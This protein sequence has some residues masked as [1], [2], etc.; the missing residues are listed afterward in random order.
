[1]TNS[2]AR[3]NLCDNT[4]TLA[5]AA[6]LFLVWGCPAG[7][8][9]GEQQYRAHRLADQAHTRRGELLS[10]QALRFTSAKTR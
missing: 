6:R 2:E 4:R 9:P 3:I 8:E 1:M 10:S 5:R 7:S